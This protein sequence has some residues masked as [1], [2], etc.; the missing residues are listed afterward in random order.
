MFAVAATLEQKVRAGR[1][2]GVNAS[3]DQLAAEFPRVLE[4]YSGIIR[5]SGQHR[6]AHS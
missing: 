4:A 3:I 1:M 6:A 2:E 5:R